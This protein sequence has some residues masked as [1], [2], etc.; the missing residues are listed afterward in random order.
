MKQNIDSVFLDILTYTD[1]NI[2]FVYLKI[3][4]LI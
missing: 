1:E 3:L 2:I 4:N